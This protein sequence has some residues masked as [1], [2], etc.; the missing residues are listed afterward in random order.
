MND[1]MTNAPWSA[2]RL[3]RLQAQMLGAVAPARQ[4]TQQAALQRFLQQ[5]LP[6]RQQEAWR[7]TPLTWL[8]AQ[9]FD[10]VTE[11]PQFAGEL[12]QLPVP[13]Y[14]LV[15]VDGHYLAS[16]SRLPTQVAGV[17]WSD[18]HTW[19]Q[20]A[21]NAQEQS[22]SEYTTAFTDLNAAMAVDGGVLQLAAGCVLDRPLHVVHVTTPGAQ[23]VMMHTRHRVVLEAGA[24]AT[25]VEEFVGAERAYL[26]NLWVTVELQVGAQLQWLKLQQ[27][28]TNAA[29][30]ATTTV[31]QQ[32][33]SQFNYLT[34]SLGGKLSRDNLNIELREPGAECQLHGFYLPRGEQLIDHHSRIDHRVPHG[35]SVQHYKGIMAERGHGVF[36]GKVVVSPAA[37]KTSASQ[38]NHNLLL[39][40]QAEIDTKPEL[41]IYADDV[42]CSHGATVGQLDAE[43]LFYLRTRGIGQ[44]LAQQLLMQAFAQELLAAFPV[45]ALVDYARA[46]MMRCL[47][48]LSCTR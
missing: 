17:T 40:A 34:I 27:E 28:G 13:C 18:W 3:E 7:Y 10:L 15:L 42:K 24:Q 1:V 25:V 4:A 38:A 41:E 46:P 19:S 8:Q 26:N 16:L 32:R 31:L 11:A 48:E 37:V 47:E 5:S 12:P 33:D 43:A 39:S 45:E 20:Q 6:T 21:A 29:H 35:T 2:Q 23:A 14:R 30:I 22:P 36:N 44:A 9:A